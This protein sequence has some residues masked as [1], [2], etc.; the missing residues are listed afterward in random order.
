MQ[1]PVCIVRNWLTA[2]ANF[3]LFDGK[4]KRQIAT[5]NACEWEK[6]YIF[7][8]TL[9]FTISFCYSVAFQ[10]CWANDWVRSAHH[11]CVRRQCAAVQCRGWRT[12]SHNIMKLAFIGRCVAAAIKNDMKSIISLSQSRAYIFW[13]LS[14]MVL[15]SCEIPF[16]NEWAISAS[17]HFKWVLA[18]IQ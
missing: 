8:V 4:W 2:Q 5:A 14:K 7:S 9:L 12:L 15:L 13:C 6:S 3:W 18:F 10:H 16:R 17:E 1:Q 11:E